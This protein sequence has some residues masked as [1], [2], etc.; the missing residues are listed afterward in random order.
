MLRFTDIEDV[1]LPPIYRMSGIDGQPGA[2]FPIKFECRSGYELIAADSAG[3]LVEARR[4]GDTEWTDLYLDPIDVSAFAPATE[5]FEIRLTP[6]DDAVYDLRILLR[7]LR[8]PVRTR[9]G[10]LVYTR[11]GHRVYT[12][13]GA[14]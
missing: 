1:P 7:T 5:T 13:P 10:N 12:T 8:H 3:V 14:E 2:P 11:S 6:S 9:D 4:L